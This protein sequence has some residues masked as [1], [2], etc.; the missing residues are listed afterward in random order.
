MAREGGVVERREG[1]K[2]GGMF[3]LFSY[4]FFYEFELFLFVY[5]GLFG[6]ISNFLKRLNE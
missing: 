6:L 2:G 3:D 5:L 4:L 1:G